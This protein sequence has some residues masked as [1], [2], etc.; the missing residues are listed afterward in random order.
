MLGNLIKTCLISVLVNDYIK[1]NYPDKY[2][3]FI[4]S[5]SYYAIYSYSKL[6]I[7]VMSFM[8]DLNDKNPKLFELK[9]MFDSLLKPKMNVAPTVDYYKNGV[10]VEDINTNECDFKIY[11]WLDKI[12]LLVNH[13]VMYDL[14][15]EETFSEISDNNFLLVEL[16]VGEKT[17]EKILLKTE[18]YNFY[19]VG[20]NLTKGFFLYY[21]KQILRI[22][23]E[24]KDNDKMSVKLIDK[25][26]NVLEIIFTDKDESILLEKNGYKLLNNAEN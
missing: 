14:D 25:D 20:N 18:E 2:E 8:K 24:I 19:V 3:S 1:R 12:N 5:L 22:S 15:E 13:K 6:Q 7:L 11:S 9:K 23:E 4:I 16:K 17:P 10:L 21:L 26:V